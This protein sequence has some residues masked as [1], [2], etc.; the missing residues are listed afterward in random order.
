MAGIEE[1]PEEV[2]VELKEENLQKLTDGSDEPDEN[3]SAHAQCAR[4]Q[5]RAAVPS[6]TLTI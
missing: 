5:R 4:G 6:A 3:A 1:L 2:I